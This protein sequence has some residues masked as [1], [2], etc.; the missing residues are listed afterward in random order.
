VKIAA[1]IVL[2]LFSIFLAYQTGIY[3]ERFTVVPL[4]SGGFEGSP[5]TLPVFLAVFFFVLLAVLSA[6]NV[7]V[8]RYFRTIRLP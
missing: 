3:A 5:I 1:R 8:N 6:G 7:L 4:Q 2:V